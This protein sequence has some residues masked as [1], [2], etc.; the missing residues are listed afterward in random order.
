MI[1]TLGDEQRELSRIDLRLGLG[2]VPTLV[3]RLKDEHGAGLTTRTVGRLHRGRLEWQGSTIDIAPF[4]FERTP[5]A[6]GTAEARVYAL[7]LGEDLQAWFDAKIVP[8][9][10]VQHGIYQNQA[11]IGGWT[12]LS[13]CLDRKFLVPETAFKERID[14][15]LS[16]GACLIRPVHQDNLEFIGTVVNTLQ[17][18]IPE[19]AGW[20]AIFDSPEPLR[21]V[22]FDE[23][24]AIP[25]DDSWEILSPRLPSRYAGHTSGTPAKL[26][27]AGIWVKSDKRMALLQ[28]L[29]RHGIAQPLSGFLTES[30]ENE[31]IYLPGPVKLG[32]RLLMCEAVT[33]SFREVDDALTMELELTS[34]HQVPSSSNT[35]VRVE[36]TFD[37][38]DAGD[39][40]Q[41]R[42]FVA[43]P[44][45]GTWNLVDPDDATLLDPGAGILAR[46]VTPTMPNDRF[47]G[48]Y[49]RHE[50]GDRVIVDIQPFRTPLVHGSWQ[51]LHDELEAATLS[52]NTELLALST[53]D[54]GTSINDAHGI[55]MDE[56][57]IMQRSGDDIIAETDTITLDQNVVITEDSVDVK[58]ETHVANK[59]KI[60]GKLEVGG[61]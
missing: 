25:L 17:H 12:F 24:H 61:M 32:D 18:H 3:L 11:E 31:L 48:L 1:V 10:G 21:F 6:A 14:E 55:V 4:G 9:K 13:N 39:D 41:Q 60:D 16:L 28:A 29:A 5:S 57:K 42:V 30:I 34:G 58:S 49:V 7:L 53:S 27:Q 33:Y 56:K 43:P 20:A 22:F 36:A 47:A 59:V 37:A 38:W 51:V 50:Q 15:F 35:P 40:A 8:G 52:L 19:L 26:K 44:P 45:N 2:A 46:F 54:S 23:E